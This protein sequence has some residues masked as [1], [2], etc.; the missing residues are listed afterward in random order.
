MLSFDLREAIPSL[1][2]VLAIGCHADDI[3]IGCGG[4]LLTLARWNRDLHVT[5][6]VLTAEGA[7][8]DEAKSSAAAFLA[9]AESVDVRIIDHR[10]CFLPYQGAEVK[11]TFEELKAVEPDLIFTH[12]RID[13]HQDHRLA[14]ELTWNTFRDHLILE[15]EIPKY[16]GDLGAPNLFVPLDQAVVA[17]KLGLIREHFPSQAERHWFDDELFRGLMRLRGMESATEYAEAFTCRK[18]LLRS[19]G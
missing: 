6:V 2:R 12:T 4:T 19:G 5:W 14:C 9:D 18:L 8:I 17:D 7:R 1:K 10:E 11:E 15:Y 3:E 13:L 16:D